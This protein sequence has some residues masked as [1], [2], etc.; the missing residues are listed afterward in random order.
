[1]KFETNDTKILELAFKNHKTLL[2]LA[3]FSEKNVTN[4]RNVTSRVF[5]FSLLLYGSYLGLS[6]IHNKIIMPYAAK[7]LLKDKEIAKLLTKG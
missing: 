7:Q 6:A 2:D 5:T 3:L 1:M 4:L